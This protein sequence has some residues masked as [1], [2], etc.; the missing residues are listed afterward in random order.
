MACAGF[1]PRGG[2]SLYDMM[3]VERASGMVLYG[4]NLWL[5]RSVADMRDRAPRRFVH[6]A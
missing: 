6:C 4:Y 3:V 5:S 2:V 1:P